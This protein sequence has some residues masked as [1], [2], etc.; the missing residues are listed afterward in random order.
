MQQR[1]Q[2]ATPTWT[3]REAEMAGE[4]S[5][6]AGGEE[7]WAGAEGPLAVAASARAG[8][9]EAQADAE[10]DPVDG[11]GTAVGE[12]VAVAIAGVEED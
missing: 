1:R 8:M 2:V 6:R 9:L 11:G 7:A 3:A 4:E 12:R 5:V 10:P